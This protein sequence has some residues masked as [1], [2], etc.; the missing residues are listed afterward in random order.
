M[1]KALSVFLAILML[2]S[3]AAPAAFAANEEKTT[4]E[5]ADFSEVIGVIT[6]ENGD[7]DW[8]T[9][10]GTYLKIFYK[11][12]IIEVIWNFFNALLGGALNDLF[13]GIKDSVTTTAQAEP[14]T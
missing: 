6:D 8:K 7:V 10:P 4:S 3:I 11:I 1:K 5:H 2:C 9:L 12:R 14:T 13:D